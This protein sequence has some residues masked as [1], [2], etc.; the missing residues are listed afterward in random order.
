M[1]LVV[2][3]AGPIGAGKTAVAQEL[4]ELWPSPLISIE[5]DRFWRFFAKRKEGD[6]REDFRLLMR[7]MTAAAVPFAREGYDVLLDFPVPPPF[8]KMARAILK[9]IPLAYVLLRPSLAVCA[10]RASERPEGKIADYNK[11]F[12]QR[13]E[14]HDPH[15][16]G[17]DNADATS[18]AKTI[19]DGIE[20]GR[21]R[22]SA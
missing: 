18:L 16:L 5:G 4:V 3:L 14:G 22:V 19:L 8:L 7:S 17:D 9:D 11:E 2:M 20:R 1:S 6:R 13:F 15:V 12:Y 10:A 21:F